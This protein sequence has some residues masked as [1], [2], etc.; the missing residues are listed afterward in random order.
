VDRL[1][2][3]LPAHKDPPPRVPQAHRSLPLGEVHLWSIELSVGEERLAR[4]ATCLSEVERERLEGI[5]DPTR[6]DRLTLARAALRSIVGAYLGVE[7]ARVPLYRDPLGRPRLGERKETA[8]GERGPRARESTE[9]A[10]SLSHSGSLAVVA[11]ARGGA[12]GVDIEHLTRRSREGLLRRALR[13]AEVEV[14]LSRPPE[15][16]EEAFLKHWTAKEA[17]G[18]ALGVGLAWDPR[19][20]SIDEALD[21]PAVRDPGD[22][23]AAGRISLRGFSPREGVVGTV[24]AGGGGWRLVEPR[25]ESLPA[26]LEPGWITAPGDS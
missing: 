25:G 18:K 2:T 21:A 12:V 11:L 22:P 23:E 6:R 20:V 17:Y 15:E 19:R 7:A 1:P 26:E 9:L 10:F 4:A 5:L 13:P 8:L 14:V 3:A 16:R 24:A